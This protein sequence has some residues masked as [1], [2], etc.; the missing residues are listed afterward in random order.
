M[1][2]DFGQNPSLLSRMECLR[3]E[4]N[5]AKIIVS[6]VLRSNCREPSLRYGT[7]YT[8]HNFPS[9][10]PALRLQYVH[11]E[12]I[13]WIGEAMAW[14]EAVRISLDRIMSLGIM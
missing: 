3:V 13:N 6:L 12:I 4:M 10:L 9:L 2:V 14:W 5:P 7:E 11:R 8:K 1:T